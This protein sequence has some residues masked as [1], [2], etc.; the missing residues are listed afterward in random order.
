MLLA[1]KFFILS[2][3]DCMR[4]LI[5]CCLCS[6]IISGVIDIFSGIMLDCLTNL[7][8]GTSSMSCTGS[9][10]GK[11]FGS[12]LTLFT[13]FFLHQYTC[14]CVYISKSWL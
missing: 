1:N 2:C 4:S 12:A 10:L 11:G 3:L 9:G 13:L 7:G 6:L 14:F 5:I 8:R